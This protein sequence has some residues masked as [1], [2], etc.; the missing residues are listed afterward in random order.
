M[1]GPEGHRTA[2]A[3]RHGPVMDPA[4]V[5]GVDGVDGALMERVAA[6][7]AEARDRIARAGGDPGRIRIV[8]V[9]K[10]FGSDEVVAALAAGLAD[11]GENYADELLAKRAAVGGVG[12][13][14]FL[15]AV[16]RNKIPRLAPV[17]DY[18]Q[19]ISRPVEGSAI[20]RHRPAVAQD[21]ESP[22]LLVEVDTTWSHGPGRLRAGRGARRRGGVA[23]ARLPCR[24]S[25]DGCAP[26]RCHRRKEGVR[27][28]RRAGRRDRASRALDGDVGGPRS[29]C[30]RG[31]D[32]GAAGDR[33]LR[34]SPATSQ[35][36]TIGSSE[37]GWHAIVCAE[38]TDVS[39][40]E[41]H[42]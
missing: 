17:V 42:R 4:G 19:G 39:R 21:L 35:A 38:G 18:W 40:V 23:R 5:D 10:G 8:A 2:C 41:G 9:T 20:L 29:G 7:V 1:A 12:T 36:V 13:W 34:S 14:H 22:A 11:V 30:G 3:R 15:G 25:D 16:Q 37:E 31:L 26:R 32:D 27:S 6:R 28:G 33:P 24:R